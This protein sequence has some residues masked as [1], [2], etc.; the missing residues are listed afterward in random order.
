MDAATFYECLA[1][2]E[3]YVTAIKDKTREEA[4][5]WPTRGA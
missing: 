4:V 2:K 5:I 3:L 1:A